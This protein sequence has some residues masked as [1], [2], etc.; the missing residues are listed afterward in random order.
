MYA[1]GYGGKIAAMLGCS[2]KVEH[3]P[4]PVPECAFWVCLKNCVLMQLSGSSCWYVQICMA[5][6]AIQGQRYA[7]PER[8]ARWAST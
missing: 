5:G 8:L 4:S 2:C 6:E 1:Q 7:P 3:W